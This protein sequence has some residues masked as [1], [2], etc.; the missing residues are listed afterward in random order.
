MT[1]ASEE[2][3]G[4]GVPG[5]LPLVTFLV[6]LA[7]LVASGYLTWEHFHDPSAQSLVCPATGAVNCVKVTTSSQSRFLGIPVAVLGFLYWLVMAG[8]TFPATWRS[9]SKVLR[10]AR[11]GLASVGMLFVLWLVYAELYLIKAICLWCTAVH[12]LTFVTFCLVLFGTLGAAIDDDE[13]YEGDAD[14][15]DDD[16][17]DLID[18]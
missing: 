11:L 16:L 7:A 3:Y 6:A 10:W 4:S 15:I 9:S 1:M 2:E 8:L 18:D 12:I 5:W 13:D 17:D 14:Y